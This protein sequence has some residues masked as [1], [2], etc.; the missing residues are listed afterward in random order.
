MFH[1]TLFKEHN[2]SKIANRLHCLKKGKSFVF[3]RIT[4]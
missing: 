4:G 2:A 1:N 3:K